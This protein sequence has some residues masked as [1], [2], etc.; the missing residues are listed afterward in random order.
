MASYL[1][2]KILKTQR[3]LETVMSLSTLTIFVMSLSA[4]TTSASLSV[5]TCSSSKIYV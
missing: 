1:H 3:E 2:A 5:R 4:I